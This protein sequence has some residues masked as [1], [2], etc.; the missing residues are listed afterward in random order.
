MYTVYMHIC[1]KFMRIC[2]CMRYIYI[3]ICNKYTRIYIYSNIYT[4]MHTAYIAI[5]YTNA[6]MC[7][8]NPGIYSYLLLA[9]I[10]F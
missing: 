10:S 3:Y 4:Y 6:T 1:M 9:F 8:S 5:V 7:Y 2:S